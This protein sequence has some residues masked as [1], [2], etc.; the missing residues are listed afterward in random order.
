[1]S[2]D[3]RTSVHGE[4]PDERPARTPVWSDVPESVPAALWPND[5]PPISALSANPCL[6]TPCEPAGSALAACPP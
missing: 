3:T 6:I 2:R 5:D 1:M 4:I